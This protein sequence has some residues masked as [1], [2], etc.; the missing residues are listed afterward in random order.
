MSNI[1]ANINGEPD[2]LS[3][4][5][6]TNGLS[7]LLESLAAGKDLNR[8]QARSVMAQMLEGRATPSEMERLLT[9]LHQKVETVDELVGFAEAMRHAAL[10]LFDAAQP[11]PDGVLVDTCGTGGDGRGTFNISTA[12]ALVVA[13]AGVRVAKHGNRS[14]TSRC[15]SADVLEALGVD[16][17]APPS[18]MAESIREVGI[19]FLFAPFFHA[20]TRH[21]Q[22]VRRKLEFRT[23]FNLLGPLT[24]PAAVDAQVVGVFSPEWLEPMAHVLSRLGVQRGFVVHSADGM[25]EV[26]LAGETAV[27]EF[28]QGTVRCTVRHHVL[29]ADDFGLP[30]SSAAGLAGG[31]AATNAAIIRSILAGTDGPP[32]DVVVANSSLALVAAGAAEDFRRA[33]ALA[34]D[35]IRSG[36]AARLLERFADFSHGRD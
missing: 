6:E 24:N 3:E 19:G 20:A 14:I 36:A 17:S 31:D 33:A 29:T 28:K 27:A 21:I 30:E 26:S 15:G 13:A 23:V 7:E 32:A 5:N 25:D 8:E 10:P 34:R 12:A 35:T 18:R 4:D 22:P 11:R 2:G 1:P 16:I 9:H